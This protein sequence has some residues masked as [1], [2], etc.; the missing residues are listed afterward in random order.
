M[1]NTELCSRG[2]GFQRAMKLGHVE[3]LPHK[4]SQNFIFSNAHSNL[5]Y[6]L[7]ILTKFDVNRRRDTFLLSEE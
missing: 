5:Q 2:A 7:S 6:F 4:T 3:T 1:R